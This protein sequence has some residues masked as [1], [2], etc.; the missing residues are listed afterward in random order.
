MIPA[1]HSMK[2]E[3]SPSVF[4][5]TSSIIAAER[6]KAED[7][8]PFKIVDNGTK[9]V[10]QCWLV[11]DKNWFE[12]RQISIELFSMARSTA[13][14]M[15][16][17]LTVVFIHLKLRNCLNTRGVGELRRPR[18]TSRYSTTTCTKRST[19]TIIP[20]LNLLAGARSSSR[21]KPYFLIRFG[22]IKPKP[23]LPHQNRLGF[24]SPGV[25][26]LVIYST[27]QIMKV[28]S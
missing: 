14:Y 23:Q 22:H 12:L 27:S 10:L 28:L 26:T 16:K 7:L 15:S 6:D 18:A 9:T 5:G 24:I 25:I 3:C 1:I 13:A 19:M 2:K 21:I 20:A 4:S 11:E 17:C 8:T